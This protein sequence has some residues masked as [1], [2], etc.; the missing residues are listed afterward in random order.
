[1]SSLRIHHARAAVGAVMAGSD[2]ARTEAPDGGA[3][4][5]SALGLAAALPK[6]VLLLGGQPGDTG[7]D[8]LPAPR[9][10]AGVDTGSDV[11][12]ADMLTALAA[13]QDTLVGAGLPSVAPPLLNDTEAAAGAAPAMGPMGILSGSIATSLT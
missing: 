10:R 13:A 2:H 4:F 8:G 3:S 11:L 5:A 6:G 1:M 12:P 7:S 9:R